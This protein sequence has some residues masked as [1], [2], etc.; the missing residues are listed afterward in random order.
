MYYLIQY[1][2][3]ICVRSVATF[4]VLHGGVAGV[5]QV[6]IFRIINVGEAAILGLIFNIEERSV[7]KYCSVHDYIRLWEVACVH[8]KVL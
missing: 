7:Q 3:Q 1:Y 6:A 8:S 2:W 4:V 5:Q